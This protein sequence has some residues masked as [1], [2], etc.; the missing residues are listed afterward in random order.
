M[1]WHGG[2]GAKFLVGG[3]VRSFLWE[4]GWVIVFHLSKFFREFY[5]DNVK[6]SE[7]GTCDSK[8]VLSLSV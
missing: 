6:T 8:K 5:I 3:R 7:I 4:G 1:H 2:E